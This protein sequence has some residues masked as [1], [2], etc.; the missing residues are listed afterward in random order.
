[1][2]IIRDPY[3][4]FYADLT[5]H[6]GASFMS[7]DAYGHLCTVT[8][9]L[10]TP[11]G[12]DFDGSTNKVT[13]SDCSALDITDAITL[14]AWVYHDA[15]ANEVFFG[16][17][18]AT[19]ESYSLLMDAA[20]KLQFRFSSGGAV[21]DTGDTALDEKTWYLLAGTYDGA[22]V[23]TLVNGAYDGDGT[24]NAGKIDSTAE[25]LYVGWGI[26]NTY[27]WDGK[28]RE[29]WVLNRA[30]TLQEILNT[31]LATKWRYR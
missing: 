15:A 25:D 11:Q 31:Y 30:L 5:K 16:K 18:G 22:I 10:W 19:D 7:D 8:G 4:K 12:R 23:R 24:A 29:A 28:V 17:W 27:A 6:D 3:L 2:E 9:A 13:I 14:M 1:M 20:E 26:S 21:L